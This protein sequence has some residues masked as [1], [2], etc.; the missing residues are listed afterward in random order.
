MNSVIFQE[1]L[2]NVSEDVKIQVDMSMA[3]ADRIDAILEAKHMTQKD[4]A[5]KMGKTEAEVCRWIGGTHNFTIS[6]IAKISA[7]LGT[8][9]IS[10]PVSYVMP[11]ETRNFVAEDA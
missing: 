9:I 1:A 2:N 4:L 11:E 5:K 3:I 7:A 8:Q 10:I 6:T